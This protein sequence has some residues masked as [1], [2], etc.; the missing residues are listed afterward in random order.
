MDDKEYYK[1]NYKEKH[2]ANPTDRNS[3]RVAQ[4]QGNTQEPKQKTAVALAYDPEDAAPKVIASGKGFLADRII[5]RAKD[6]DIPLHQDEKLAHSLSKIE[7]G[8]MIPPELYEIVAEVLLFVDKM[9]R[10]KNKVIK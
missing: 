9:D 10:I 8:D 7:I 1:N 3:G 5:E 6:Q 4:N 2:K